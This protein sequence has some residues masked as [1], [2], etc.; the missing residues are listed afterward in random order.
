MMYKNGYEHLAEALPKE[1]RQKFLDLFKSGKS[2]GEAKDECGIEDVMV[3]CAI[4]NLNIDH[5]S[6]FG[7]V[8]K[9][10]E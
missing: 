3:A 6:S 10:G 8:D 4:I 1:T 5:Y 2:I 9:V 7:F